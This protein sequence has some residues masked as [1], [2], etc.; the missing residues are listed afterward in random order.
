MRRQ[1]GFTLIELIT[2]IVILGIISVVVIPR[3]N[4]VQYR[5]QEFHDGVLSALRYAQKSAVSHRRTVCITFAVD[6]V[7]LAMDIDRNG[8]CAANE[9][10]LLPGRNVEVVQS[11]DANNAVFNPVPAN[12]NFLS[13]GTASVANPPAIQITNQPNTI[14]VNGTTGYVE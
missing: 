9:A 8:V 11:R 4:N 14:V 10:L 13:D 7:T 3:L 12:F 1:V 6:S 2:I 5:S